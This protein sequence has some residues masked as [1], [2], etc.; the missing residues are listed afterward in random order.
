MAPE[1]KIQKGY[2]IVGLTPVGQVPGDGFRLN[3]EENISRFKEGM[4]WNCILRR[5][6]MK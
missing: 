5:T 2:R 4:I 6:P 3:C 1:K